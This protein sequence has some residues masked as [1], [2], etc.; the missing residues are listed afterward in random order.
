MEGGPPGAEPSPPTP[1]SSSSGG[2]LL[3]L[4]ALDGL[5]GARGWERLMEAGRGSRRQLTWQAA[6]RW[7]GRAARRV[8]SGPAEEDEPSPLPTHTHTH[9]KA[10]EATRGPW[11]AAPTRPPG[12][13]PG[14][15][16]AAGRP[17]RPLPP[18]PPPDPSSAR[19]R[20]EDVLMRTSRAAFNLARAS[21]F[22]PGP[23]QGRLIGLFGAGGVQLPLAR[24]AS[25]GPGAGA[26]HHYAARREGPGGT[27]QP[28]R[29]GA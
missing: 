14:L 26:T 24:K 28:C 19:P 7:P 17:A 1:S 4:A 8:V 27:L 20:E 22:A 25:L 23:E 5:G 12:A 11:G 18:A 29:G 6:A 10:L 9:A 13:P 15:E 3:A 16:P 21:G 2:R